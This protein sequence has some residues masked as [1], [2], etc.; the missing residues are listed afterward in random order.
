MLAIRRT[1]F[2]K[3]PW[4]IFSAVALA[5][6]ATAAEPDD[7]FAPGRGDPPSGDS[8]FDGDDLPPDDAG[9]DT[10]PDAPPLPTDGTPADGL[11][12]TS[13]DANPPDANPPDANP[14]DVTPPDANPPDAAPEAGP[15]DATPPDS[16]PP[17]T[18]PPDTGGGI[19]NRTLL[20]NEVQM[21]DP[22]SSD[23]RSAEF[24]ELYNP[25][26]CAVP[27]SN[28]R[29][30]Y[31]RLPSDS[32]IVRWNG[33]TVGATLAGKSYYVIASNAFAGTRDEPFAQIYAMGED[34]AGFA[35]QRSNATVDALGFGS[36]TYY[37]G[38]LATAP[39][40]GFSLARKWSGGPVD[41]NNNANDF[42][43]TTQ[44]TPGAQNRP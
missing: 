40:M 15:P 42:W 8:A 14:P 36:R 1:V 28:Y 39:P 27:L 44:I 11:A 6:C 5:A 23:I 38:N 31:K 18:N 24:I 7:P 41:T 4:W 21:Q 43:L 19:C 37:E 20:I 10:E 32:D 17:D 9:A 22:K 2:A 30:L 12:E 34:Q 13:P 3:Y 26:D 35:L 33:A 16:N 25:N 29:I